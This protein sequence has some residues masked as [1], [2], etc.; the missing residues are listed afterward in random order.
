MCVPVSV[1]K[2]QRSIFFIS[3]WEGVNLSFFGSLSPDLFVSF[4]CFYDKRP[5]VPEPRGQWG[6]HGATKCPF[7]EID[8]RTKIIHINIL[9]LMKSRFQVSLGAYMQEESQFFP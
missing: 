1:W 4:F 2:V 8:F 9:I 5:G 3:F 6:Q 7:Q